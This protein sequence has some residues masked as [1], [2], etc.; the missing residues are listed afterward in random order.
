MHRGAPTCAES[1]ARTAP[2]TYFTT[3]RCYTT[4]FQ[5]DE[6]HD[7]SVYVICNTLR[8]SSKPVHS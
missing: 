6:T 3:I 5:H 4:N 7:K 8:K 1:R 2:S